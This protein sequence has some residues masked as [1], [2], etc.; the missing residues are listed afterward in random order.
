MVL[1]LLWVEGY[2]H[3]F[4]GMDGRLCSEA[5]SFELDSYS[6]TSGESNHHLQSVSAVKNDALPVEPRGRLI[7]RHPHIHRS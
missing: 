7:E 3:V 4:F 5:R 1:A 2:H 6:R